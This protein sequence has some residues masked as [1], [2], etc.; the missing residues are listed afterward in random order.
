MCASHTV[1]CVTKGIMSTILLVDDDPLQA[2]L[3][4]SLLERKFGDVRRVADAAEALCLVEQPQF[5]GDLGLVI[6][7]HHLPGIGG[8]AFV[9]E[10]HTRMPS[11]P[12]LVLGDAHEKPADYMGEGIRFLAR[13]VA[14]EE[15]ISVAGQ[16]LKRD[17]QKA[18]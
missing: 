18:N 12:V 9:E 3:C 4:K 5:A 13:P 11:L 10:L 15:M 7:G 14:T 1:G 2:Y 16:L 17:G 6:S 8:P